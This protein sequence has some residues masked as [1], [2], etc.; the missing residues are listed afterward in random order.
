MR[1]K[2]YLSHAC[3]LY[4]DT[5][6]LFFGTC[7]HQRMCNDTHQ[8]YWYTDRALDTWPNQFCTRQCLEKKAGAHHTL[9]T[10]TFAL[11]LSVAPKT[12]TASARESVAFVDA[13]RINVAPLFPFLEPFAPVVVRNSYKKRWRFYQ[14]N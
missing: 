7:I 13:V 12:W 4:F 10:I 5:F 3:N 8:R 11:L 6:W 9:L 1:S 14:V 2:G